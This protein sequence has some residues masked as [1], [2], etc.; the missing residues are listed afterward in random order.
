MKILHTADWH[1]GKKLEYFSRFEEQVA[2]LDE[3]CHI[4]ASEA[5]DVVVIAG[6]IFDNF[7]PSTE[8]TALLYKTLKRLC[9]NGNRLVI[10]IAGNHDSPDRID[11]PDSLAKELGIFFIGYPNA[12]IEPITIDSGIQL[13]KSDNGFI[14]FKLPKFD[15]PLRCLVTPFPNEI[16][17]KTFLGDDKKEIELNNWLQQHWQHLADAYCD[18][19]GCNIAIAH[20]FMQTKYG[21]QQSEPEGERSIIVG[22]ASIIPTSCIPKQIQYTALGHLHNFQNIHTKEQPIV[23]SSSPLAYSFAEAG[24]EKKVVIVTLAPNQAPTYTTRSLQS[25]RKLYRKKFDTIDEAIEWLTNHQNILVELSIVTDTYLSNQS[26]KALYAANDGII[27][28]IPIMETIAKSNDIAASQNVLD[29]S[30]EAY[31]KQYFLSEKNT[32]PNDDLLLLFKEILNEPL[33]K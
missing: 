11:L 33:D 13:T 29:N 20:L 8:A 22:T 6:D 31:F 19:K 26:L 24:Q 17:L 3:I 10:G 7:N 18:S 9:D 21:D 16:R 23:Y 30:I 25:G 2:V 14:E 28:I 12:I 32:L 15:Y 5:V 1:L 27:H 4:A